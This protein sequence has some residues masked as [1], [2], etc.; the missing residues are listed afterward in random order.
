MSV[1][2]GKSTRHYFRKGYARPFHRT[3][4]TPALSTQEAAALVI[5]II[6]ARLRDGWTL[7]QIDWQRYCRDQAVV[8]VVTQYLEQHTPMHKETSS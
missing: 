4:R 2:K 3:R 7:D 8:Q 1:P 6:E 5:G